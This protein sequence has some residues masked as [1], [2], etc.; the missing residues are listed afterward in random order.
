MNIFTAWNE[1]LQSCVPGLARP[2]SVTITCT[3]DCLNVSSET[4]IASIQAGAAAR[5]NTVDAVYSHARVT[6]QAAFPRHPIAV[7]E[8]DS[9]SNSNTQVTRKQICYALASSFVHYVPKS[10]SA[11]GQSVVNPVSTRYCLHILLSA[12]HPYCTYPHSLSS[13][14]HDLIQSFV[15]LQV[16]GQERW[17]LTD[18]N[19]ANI[20]ILPWHL[21]AVL[22]L[23]RYSIESLF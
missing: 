19:D 22:L 14:L 4:S 20:A 2:A 13:H 9:L 7:F 1:L 6:V 21:A 16:L 5:T 3:S 17:S 8:D 23:Q 18:I 10:I 11:S 15:D 12:S